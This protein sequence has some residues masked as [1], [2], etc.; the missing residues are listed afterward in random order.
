MATLYEEVHNAPGG[1]RALASA[2]LRYRV[3]S[4]LSEAL[5]ASGA[6]QSAVADRLKVRRSAANQ[7]FRGS[8]N[9]RVNTLA[10][11]LDAMGFELTL[12]IAPSGTARGAQSSSAE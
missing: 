2:R 7:V 8:G 10:E 9:L 4:V 11:Y 3:L 1:R 5:E 6:T 12:A